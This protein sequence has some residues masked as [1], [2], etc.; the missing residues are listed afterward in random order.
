[1]VDP[2]EAGSAGVDPGCSAN[3]LCD[4]AGQPSPMEL[5]DRATWGSG[6]PPSTQAVVRIV[7]S[8][9]VHLYAKRFFFSAAFC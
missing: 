2:S 6:Q 7:P 8:L 1:M 5:D 9:L 4:A 3:P